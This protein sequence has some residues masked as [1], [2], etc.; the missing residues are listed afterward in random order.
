MPRNFVCEFCHLDNVNGFMFI[1]KM[2]SCPHTDVT[3]GREGI[4]C[5]LD[6]GAELCVVAE[7]L[8]DLLVVGGTPNVRDQNRYVIL[9]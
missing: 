6:T 9:S 8:C 7:I 1:I 5:T 2:C 3:F 4:C